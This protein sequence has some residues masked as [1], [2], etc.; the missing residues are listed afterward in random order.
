[1]NGGFADSFTTTTTCSIEDIRCG[2]LTRG[3]ESDSLMADLRAHLADALRGYLSDMPPS[4][5]DWFGPEEMA[6]VLLSLPGIAIVELPKGHD[7][8]PPENPCF[9]FVNVVTCPGSRE[10]VDESTA[11]PR[12]KHNPATARAHAGML[13]AA[14][15]AAEEG[16]NDA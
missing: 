4:I 2:P 13:L 16:R 5:Q 12:R 3:W 6:D 15:I 1:M 11:W 10:I 14:A 7:V 9:Q 8:G